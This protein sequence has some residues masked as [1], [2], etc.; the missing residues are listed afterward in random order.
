MYANA[1]T[2][3]YGEDG[4]AAVQ[5]FVDRGA[6]VGLWSPTTVDWAP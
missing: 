6:S 5:A 3:D 1:R 2:L 4:R